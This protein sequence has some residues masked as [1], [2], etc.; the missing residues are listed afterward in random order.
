MQRH[1]PQALPDAPSPSQPG[2]AV[3]L[4][5]QLSVSPARSSGRGIESSLW[6]YLPPVD[7]ELWFSESEPPTPFPEYAEGFHVQFPQM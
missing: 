3:A 5:F 6:L 2:F 7:T 4:L 1:L